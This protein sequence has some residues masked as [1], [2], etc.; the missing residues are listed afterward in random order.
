VTQ[1]SSL[2]DNAFTFLLAVAIALPAFLGA[3]S[4]LKGTFYALVTLPTLVLLLMGKI[5]LPE[6]F[7]SYPLVFALAIP[8]VYWSAVN[9]WSENP[10]NFASYGRRAVTTFVYLIAVAHIASV[11]RQTLIRYMDFALGLV[12]VG[13]LIHLASIFSD[14]PRH[15]VWRLGDNTIFHRSLHAAQYFGVF[16]SYG[17]VRFYQQSAANQRWAFLA[18]LTPCFLF[19]VL[20]FSRGPISSLF[21]VY[22]FI[23]IFWYKKYRHGLIALALAGA[24]ALFFLEPLL[25]RGSS[26]RLEIWQLSFELVQQNFWLGVGFGERLDLPYGDGLLAPHAHNLF[27]EVLV[28]SGVM[29]LLMLLVI[30]G[31]VAFKA[32]RPTPSEQL[33]LAPLL[34]FFTAMMTDVQKLVNSPSSAYVVIWLPLV[35]LLVIAGNNTRASKPL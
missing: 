4:S 6:L 27:L 29:G 33:C 12:A 31:Y 9:L 21:A 32:W 14:E 16:A 3:D 8:L 11:Q 15:L 35:A 1:S 17:L 24:T 5:K 18:A 30:A 20:T 19:V 2:T 13:A 28:R 22:L 23:A 34:F 7:R 25:E 26:F 10:D